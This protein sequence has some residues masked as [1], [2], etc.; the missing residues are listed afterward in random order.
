MTHTM[1]I[2]LSRA[3]QK[4]TRRQVE[5]KIRV[6]SPKALFQRLNGPNIAMND[7]VAIFDALDY[8]LVFQ[9][10]GK[11]ALPE[12]CYPIRLSDYNIE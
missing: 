6:S 8:Q 12:K 4:L 7:F 9:P 10:K 1:A 5:G 11:E 3:H 2:K